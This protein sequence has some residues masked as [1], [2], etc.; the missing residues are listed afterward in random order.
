MNLTI[1]ATTLAEIKYALQWAQQNLGKHTRPS[2]IDQALGSISEIL[3]LSQSKTPD[4]SDSIP[5]DSVPSHIK[6]REARLENSTRE[7]TADEWMEAYR[8]SL[9]IF[10]RNQ[11]K[12]RTLKTIEDRLRENRKPLA[13]RTYPQVCRNPSSH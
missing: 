11:A 2:P 9:E 4:L 13:D 1:P 10:R 5:A 12:V 3:P 8:Q 6:A 7:Y